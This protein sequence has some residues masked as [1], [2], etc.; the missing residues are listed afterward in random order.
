[1]PSPCDEFA[2]AACFSSERTPSRSFFIAASATRLSP[3]EASIHAETDNTPT[4]PIKSTVMILLRNIRSPH[5]ETQSTVPVRPYYR[6]NYP[7]PRRADATASGTYSQ[8]A[9][10]RA[11]G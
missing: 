5:K 6:Q 3:E 2:S 10:R 4:V 9:Y 1:M 7:H 11:P 8:R